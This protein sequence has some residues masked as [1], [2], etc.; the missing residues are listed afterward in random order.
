MNVG[1]IVDLV[2]GDQWHYRITE[3][4][5]QTE[6]GQSNMANIVNLETGEVLTVGTMQLKEVKNA[7]H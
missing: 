6:P 3:I 1:D 2:P 5:G 4:F 7:T